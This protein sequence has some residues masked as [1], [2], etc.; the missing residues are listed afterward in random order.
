MRRKFVIVISSCLS[1][2]VS[3]LLPAPVSANVQQI[4]IN[5]VIYPIYKPDFDSPGL[6]SRSSVTVS[7]ND[8]QPFSVQ[9]DIIEIKLR[10]KE[11]MLS[12]LTYAQKI[13]TKDIYT[14]LEVTS[15][16]VPI[17][18]CVRDI[19][20]KYISGEINEVDVLITYKKGFTIVVGEF[21]AKVTLLAKTPEAQAIEKLIKDC[22]F[23]SK[24]NWLA[25]IEQTEKNV[26]KGKPI[27]LAGTFFRSGIPSPG[28]TLRIYQDFNSDPTR[29][30]VRLLATSQT[31]SNGVFS[32]TFV[33][34]SK[35]GIYT[36]TF[37]ART[38]PLGPL[39][40]PFESGSFNVFVDCGAKC[41]YKPSINDWIPKHSDT[42]ITAF[43]EYDVN[44]A[45]KSDLGLM[46]PNSDG[47]IPF[48]YRKVFQG[49]ASKKSYFNSS[50]ADSG[51]YSSK[52][53]SS[54]SGGRCYVSGYTTKTGKRVSGYYR[55]C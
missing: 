10:A 55:D 14:N 6:C 40:G 27:T 53:S 21:S 12:F 26:S 43:A 3:N 7:R 5:A 8:G 13:I 19:T 30:N 44:F 28:D 23:E 46:Y 50:A 32:F 51:G 22:S 9:G 42:C 4:P 1:V 17:Q 37:Q 52:S 49:S 41:N 18:L 16:S 47:R 39:S 48:L 31:D 24:P 38:S 2:F 11:S 45:S 15:V 54:K 29:G 33:P 36:V 20:G 25:T 34:K 35:N